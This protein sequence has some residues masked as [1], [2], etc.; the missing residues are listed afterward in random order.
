[1][2]LCIH[3][4]IYIHLYIYKEKKDYTP[5]YAVGRLQ[6]T[7]IKPLRFGANKPE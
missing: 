6:Y 4:S 7:S 5:I 1:M 3:I 2:R